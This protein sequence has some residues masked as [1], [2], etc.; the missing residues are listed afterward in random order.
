[1][2]NGAQI[3]RKNLQVIGR[4]MKSRTML[5]TVLSNRDMTLKSIKTVI[6]CS[7]IFINGCELT[8]PSL[9]VEPPKLKTSG[10]IIED[11][12]KHCPP[13]QAKKGNC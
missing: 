7:F 10:V 8:G 5:K 9:K 13:G 6:F 12:H 1:M 11:H 3:L 2:R 4:L